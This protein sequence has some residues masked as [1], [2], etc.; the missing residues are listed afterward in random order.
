LSGY[1]G[2]GHRLEATPF[3]SLPTQGLIRYC[4]LQYQYKTLKWISQVKNTLFWIF[5]KNL[6]KV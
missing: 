6:S 2:V 1:G 4:G 5:L 3:F